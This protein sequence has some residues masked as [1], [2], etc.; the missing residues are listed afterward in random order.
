VDAAEALQ[1]KNML[2]SGDWITQHLNGTPYFDKAPL[3]YWITACLYSLFGI[4]D[5]VARL[6]TALSAILLCWLVVRMG[7]W[8][9]SPD[10]GFYSGLVLATSIGLFL[11][12]RTIIPDVLLTLLIAASFSCLLHALESEHASFKW[13]L[14]MYAIIGCAVLTKGLIGVFFPVAIG[15]SFLLLSR[16]FHWRRLHLIPGIFLF[17]V[18]TVPWHLLATLHNPP[19]LDLTLHPGPH[20]GGIFRGFFWFYFINEQLLRFLNQRWPHDYNTTPRLWFWLYHLLW[21][22]PWSLYL[23]E[24]VRFNF[25]P[26]DRTGRL[27]LMALCWIAVVMVFFT[28]S[29]TQEYYSMPIYPAVAILLGSAMVSGNR[30]LKWAPII[31]AWLFFASA[32]II[33]IILANVRSLA[34][35][36]DIF[37]ALIQHPSLYTL[38]LG[39][40]ADLTLSAFAY[41]KVPLELA[42]VA[43]LIGGL[44]VI[45]LP[46]NR[47]YVAIA[48]TML[49]FFQ[50]AHLALIVFDPYLSSYNVARKLNQF[51]KG[52]L[53]VCGKYN[54]LSSLFFYSHDGAIQDESDLDILEY[55]SLAPGAATISISDDQMKRLWEGPAHV[56]IVAKVAKL[57]HLE[58]VLGNQDSHL[59]FQSADKYLFA[60]HLQ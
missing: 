44:S 2:L 16:G 45:V 39:H 36:G 28:F 25:K 47:G 56:Y 33:A 50:A 20:F 54:P 19:V 31:T 9:N 59:A 18:I 15:T 14:S 35:P 53:I 10:V 46:R 29:T 4:H 37:T 13:A 1:A 26:Q 57:R 27:R 60:N 6:P 23:P 43:F 11:F 30:L 12:T 48:L 5:W 32:S 7:R 55:G 41:L 3:K 17:L 34:T 49:V 51:P 24:I 42:G 52:I 58:D 21:F 40:I 8:A 38:S 22:C